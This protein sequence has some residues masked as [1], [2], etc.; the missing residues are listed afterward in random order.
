[1]TWMLDTNTVSHLMRAHPT[2]TRRVF[3]TPMNALCISAITEAELRFGLARRPEATRLHQVVQE[4]LLRVQTRVWDSTAAQ[5]YGVTRAAMQ[6]DGRP[7]G[8]LDMLIAAHAIA[9][10]SVL[11]TS[12]QAFGMVSGLNREDWAA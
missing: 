3:A 12:D 6:R 5:A 2:V 9:T 11:V 4:F 10:D 1:M 7:L 8:S